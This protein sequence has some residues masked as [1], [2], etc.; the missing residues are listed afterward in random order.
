MTS[1][2]GAG[3]FEV[4]TR[5]SNEYDIYR[6]NFLTLDI[7]YGELT[8][9]IVEMTPSYVMESFFSKF[10]SCKSVRILHGVDI[11]DMHEPRLGVANWGSNCIFDTICFAAVGFGWLASRYSGVIMGTMVSQIISLTIVHSTVHSGAD[12]RKHQSS[13]SLAFVRGIH[14][15]PVNSSHKWPVTRKMFPFDDVIMLAR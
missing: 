3:M 7:Y 14:R 11:P 5:M 2:K 9:R 6:N 12:Q 4:E 15:G 1:W 8:R 13:A 10:V